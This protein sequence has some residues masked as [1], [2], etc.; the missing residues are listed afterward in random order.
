MHLLVHQVKLHLLLLLEE[1]VVGHSFGALRSDSARAELV[2]N[3]LGLECTSSEIVRLDLGTLILSSNVHGLASRLE[4]CGHDGL[5][6]HHRWLMNIMTFVKDRLSILV[7]FI[8]VG[9]H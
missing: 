2:L 3:L 9:H 8:I 1:L 5:L 4:M 7:S 6:V